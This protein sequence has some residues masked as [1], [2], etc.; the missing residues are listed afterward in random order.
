ML[1][2]HAN[3]ALSTSGLSVIRNGYLPEQTIQ[4]AFGYVEIK[5]TKVVRGSSQRQRNMLQDLIASDLS[6][7]CKKHRRVATMELYC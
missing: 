2:Q 5:V 4:T 3:A 1:K 7:S 6:Q